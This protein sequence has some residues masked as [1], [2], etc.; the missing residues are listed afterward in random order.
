MTE[1]SSEIR[2]RNLKRRMA[3]DPT[4]PLFIGLAEE[5]RASGRLSDAV[6]VL[7]KGVLTFPHYL[8]AKVALARAYLEAGHTGDAAVLFEKALAMDPGN[9][10]SARALADIALSRGD[11]LEAIKKLRLYRALSADRNVDAT[12]ARI[13]TELAQPAPGEPRGRVLARLYLEQGHPAE[14]LEV[15][16]DLARSEPGDPEIEALRKEAASR[17]E[18][19]REEPGTPAAVAPPAGLDGRDRRDASVRILKEWA[20]RIRKAASAPSP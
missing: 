7:E 2:I 9:L 19:R 8:S 4:S 18:P 1:N 14:A 13:E 11:R 3:Q 6:R 10:V 20:A 16:E 15:L 5:Y 17:L 12:I